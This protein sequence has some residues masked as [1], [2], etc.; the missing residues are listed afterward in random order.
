VSIVHDCHFADFTKTGKKAPEH[1]LGYIPVQI[2]D[3]DIQIFPPILSAV[4]PILA[5]L[6]AADQY[7]EASGLIYARILAIRVM[8]SGFKKNGSQK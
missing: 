5:H 8:S 3:I 6:D 7:A 2:A 4:Y 1:F